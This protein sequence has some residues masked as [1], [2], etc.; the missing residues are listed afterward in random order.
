M[1][2]LIYDLF[3]GVG[4]CNQ[5]FSLETAIYLAN[6]TNRKLILL[7]KNPL[8]HCG[9]ASWDY[10]H[11][12]DYFSDD[13]KKFLPYGIEVY[14]KVIPENIKN[15]IATSE[16]N[17]LDIP[18]RFSSAVFVDSQYKMD[19]YKEDIT[20]FCNGRNRLIM[21]FDKYEYEYIYINTSNASRCFYNFYTN[22]ERYRLM[23]NICNSLSIL[24]TNI[25]EKFV[26]IDNNHDVSI[27]LRLG[28]YHKT[29]DDV[30]TNSSR[31]SNNL[32]S[33]IDK[34][35]NNN[36]LVMCDRKDA[37]V[38]TLLKDKY[39]VTF[40]DELI[41]PSGNPIVDFLMEKNMC[42]K[43]KYFIGTSGSTVSNYINYLFYLSN[44]TFHLYSNKD[45]STKNCE[46]YSWNINNTSGH[47][48]SW[49]TF[50]EDNI[51]KNIMLTS[52]HPYVYNENL[53][54]N[55]KREININPNKNK[56]IIS[57]CLYGLNNERNRKRDFEKG[58]YVNYYY[59]K[60]HNYK[61]WTMRVYIPYNEPSDI[62]DT[63]V[64]FGD[65]E[66]VLVDTN[67]C[68]RAL[69]FLP[70]DDPNVSVWI[71][72]DL[73][74]ILNNREEHAV[75][76]WLNHKMDKELMIMSDNSQHTWAL[77]GGMFGKI[78][79]NTN[80][81]ISEFIVKYS[82]T[83]RNNIDK[84]A[85][86]CEIAEQYFYTEH[87]YIQYYRAGKKLDNSIPFPD[88]SAIHC[89]FVGNIS[90]I[91]KYYTDLHLESIYPFL[92][93]T[94]DLNNN[95]T[96]L[97]SPWS[98][99]FK[100]SLPLCILLWQGDDFIVTVDPKRF[101]GNGTFKTMNGDGKKILTLNTHI[102]IFWEGK[103]YLEAYMPN[104]E[105]ITV[106]HGNNRPY[107][108]TKHRPNVS[109]NNKT[110]DKIIIKSNSIT[111]SK[112]KDKHEKKKLF[113]IDLHTSVIEEVIDVFKDLND[114]IDVTQWSMSGHHWVFN[115]QKY[116][117]KYIN[118]T[119]WENIDMEM[120]DNFCNE[121]NEE[122]LK[123]DG[124]IVTHSPI[125]CLLYER[126]KKPIFLINSCRYVLPYCWKRNDEMMNVL[127]K[128]LLEMY[129][130]DL[131]FIV[132]NN[133]ADRDFLKLGSSIHSYYSPSL[134]LYTK[135]KYTGSNDKF[136][137]LGNHS[138]I[139]ESELIIHKKNALFGRYSWIDLYKYKGLIILP[140]EISTMSLFEYYSANIP[141]IFPSKAFL[142]QLI[143]L[144]KISL[145]SRYFKYK[146]YPK[147]LEEPLGKNYVDWWIDR[148]DFY[149]NMKHIIFYDNFEELPDIL[150]GIRVKDVSLKMMFWNNIRQLTTKSTYSNFIT[151]NLKLTTN[152]NRLTFNKIV[153]ISIIIPTY[154]PHFHKIDN[155][156][157]NI[158]GQ[159]SYVEEV[160]ICA[161]QCSEE[162]GMILQNTLISKY[163]PLFNII[164][165][166]TVERN[167]PA[168]NRNRGINV[169]K[170]KYI[171]NLDCD[172]FS[173]C[174]KIEIMYY[175]I[176]TNPNVDL[177]CHNYILDNIPC[178][179]TLNF[180]I[181]INNLKTYNDVEKYK[182][183][184][185]N[186]LKNKP[187]CTN[188]VIENKWIHHAHI[189]FNKNTGIRFNETKEYFKR[190]DGKLCQD[191]LFSGKNL[192]YLDEK[193]TLY[194]PNEL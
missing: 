168:E 10:G 23:S 97:Y 26:N 186:M 91:L 18:N 171:M 36:L 170:N 189:V 72:R 119:T 163:E 185:Q 47:S 82:N 84:F 73:D 90:P 191:F 103:T 2:Y 70:N 57:Y 107:N 34:L 131:L 115:K 112:I 141:L 127:N 13:Y 41:K 116:N 164:V 193:L 21:D 59:M 52:N 158:I 32:I 105:T 102:Q 150:R 134:C 165:S 77:A 39:T 51:Y 4:F 162:N 136:L 149:N 8:C 29:Q 98:C 156:I 147:T 108:F 53:Y 89:G 66:I 30:N 139:K 157:C 144:G 56:K 181:D 138:L 129:N 177:I 68:L 153:P 6:I 37:D 133:I 15:I 166:T 45:L 155:L 161:S 95:E 118:S 65:I 159:T 143:K 169:S 167:N 120:I 55:I 94:T 22:K 1:K 42:E 145:G 74:S 111:I 122:L 160:I 176:K 27:H 146:D 114:D 123:Y 88:L 11:F 81:T 9:R 64:Q 130:N 40:T 137:L 35:P 38:I 194:K 16:C 179:E 83:T 151:D 86:D 93:N 188:M 154:P 175:L 24:N 62:I 92:C 184:T 152:I 85:N 79:N 19:K 109:S 75:N 135:E 117:L 113:N 140:Y 33:T 69:R 54:I 20:L 125:F 99:F 96:F 67:V 172:D 12:L 87:N 58:V 128:K 3:S 124:F 78:N 25:I 46:K 31:Y 104:K 17:K 106:I 101:I 71:S 173:H 121:Y 178:S 132:S 61:D 14:Y 100:N 182:L 49:S 110:T 192:L 48:I 5:L 183:A 80:N 180:N 190:E 126:Y 76:D 60:N 63:I 7:I 174:R 142:K 50:W 43:S 28:D 187:T 44:K 148:A